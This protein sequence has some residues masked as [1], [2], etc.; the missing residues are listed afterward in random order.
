MFQETY[1]RRIAALI[2]IMA[3]VA[4]IAYTYSTIK[5]ARYLYNGP[6]SISVNGTGEAFGVPDV[7]TFNHEQVFGTRHLDQ[8]PARDDYP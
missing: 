8:F 4:L 6:T 2:G 3:I 1:M 7:A 5:T